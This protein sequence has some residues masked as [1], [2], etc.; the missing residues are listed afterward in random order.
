[1]DLER[2]SVRANIESYKLI[3]EKTVK[4][5]ISSLMIPGFQRNLLTKVGLFST[6]FPMRT[7]A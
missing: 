1:M 2:M 7:S 3:I 5:N 4:I 6:A